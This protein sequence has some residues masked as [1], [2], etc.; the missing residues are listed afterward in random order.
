MAD[1]EAIN[2]YHQGDRGSASVASI[3]DKYATINGGTITIKYDGSSDLG[4][5]TWAETLEDIV[6]GFTRETIGSVTAKLSVSDGVGVTTNAASDLNLHLLRKTWQPDIIAPSITA[7]DTNPEFA[8]Q[9]ATGK[10]RVF[11]KTLV[12]NLMMS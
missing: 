2:F 4:V 10:A 5:K 3:Y 1:V 8:A 6:V 12:H 7:N 11:V 9:F